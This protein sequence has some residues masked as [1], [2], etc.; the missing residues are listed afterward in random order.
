M[1]PPRKSRQLEVHEGGAA[2]S[3]RKKR[4]PQSIALPHGFD[5]F[6]E[7]SDSV[8]EVALR[9][10]AALRTSGVSLQPC[11]RFALVTLAELW[12]EIRFFKKSLEE[13]GLMIKGERGVQKRNP[14]LSSLHAARDRFD[15]LSRRFGMTPYDW[16]R[17]E[18]DPT[19]GAQPDER[20]GETDD[21]LEALLN[22]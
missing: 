5:S 17:I 13:E 3:K 16:E 22:S 12:T 18:A 8:E 2:D 14:A 20:E 15:H 9:L 21:A 19:P 11:H 10:G 6:P 1:P 4:A 7:C